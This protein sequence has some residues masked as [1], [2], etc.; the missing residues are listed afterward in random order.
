MKPRHAWKSPLRLMFGLWLGLLGASIAMAQH[1]Q[2]AST[3][4]THNTASPTEKKTAMPRKPRPQ[5]GSSVAFDPQGRL[6]LVGLNTQGHLF[7]QHTL[8]KG[9]QQWSEPRRLDVGDDAI[10]ADGEN[11]PKLAWGPAGR[12]VISYTQTLNK[13]F[14]GMI[15]MLRSADDGA[16]FSPPF[17]VHQDRQIITHRFESVAFDARGDLHT[18][19]IDKR[20]L[21]QAPKVNGKPSYAGAAIYA[22]VSKDGG[23]SFGPDVKVAAHTCECCRIALAPGHD[24]QLRAMWRHVFEGNIRDHAFAALGADAPGP[25]LRASNDDWHLT[26]CPHHGPG[27][28]RADAGPSQ[29]Y[30]YHAVW[31]GSRKVRG[32]EVLAVRYGRLSEGGAPDEATVRELP[33]AQ[34]EHADVA[35]QGERVV[36]VWRSFN[37]EQWRLRAWVSQDGGRQFALR[38]LAQTQAENDHP[39]VAQQNGRMVVVWRDVNK[40]NVH[41]ITH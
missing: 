25:I 27:L 20:D 29:G 4:P 23:Q 18:L 34:A 40:V 24:G 35:A 22:N 28:A 32:Q 12:V 16:S 6:W 3:A 13:P 26:G 21:E 33:D 1:T 30:G 2:S 19:W 9:L 14:T 8:D 37:G 7:V 5:L 38:E 36:I 15:R 11:R 31:F 41:E 39:R 17:T 10:S